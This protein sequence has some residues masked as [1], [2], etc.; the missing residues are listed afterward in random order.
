MRAF[1]TKVRRLLE[2]CGFDVEIHR[3]EHDED[4]RPEIFV[5]TKRLEHPP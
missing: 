2:S 3:A 5:G 1:G 4:A